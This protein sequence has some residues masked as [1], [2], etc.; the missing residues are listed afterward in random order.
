MEMPE[1][2]ENAAFF[3]FA[4][5]AAAAANAGSAD[6]TSTGASSGKTY[7]EIYHGQL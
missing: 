7:F 2:G 5:Q 6:S 3:H 4:N 1:M